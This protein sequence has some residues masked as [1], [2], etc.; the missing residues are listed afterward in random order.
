MGHSLYSFARK[1]DLFKKLDVMIDVGSKSGSAT[2]SCSNV[3]LDGVTT[4]AVKKSMAPIA[5]SLDPKTKSDSGD[6]KEEEDVGSSTDPRA[7]NNSIK[8]A[9]RESK[10]AI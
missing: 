10:A 4:A 8:V 5:T 1:E 6:S 9:Q 3:T 2:A 7:I